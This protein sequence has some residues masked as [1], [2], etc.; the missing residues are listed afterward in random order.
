MLTERN[1]L[2]VLYADDSKPMKKPPPLTPE[3]K[4]LESGMISKI[5]D[6]FFRASNPLHKEIMKRVAVF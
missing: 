4:R 1:E 2:L 3:E 5:E 6:K